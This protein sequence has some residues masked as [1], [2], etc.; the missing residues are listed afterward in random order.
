MP[1]IRKIEVTDTFHDLTPYQRAMSVWARW[2]RLDDHKVSTGEAH[3]QDV[4][5]MMRTAEAIETM[6]NDMPRHLWWAVRKGN[7]ICTVWNF[8][9]INLE[10]ALIAAEEKLT[11]KMKENVVTRRFFS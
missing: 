9:L 7:G 11:V 8:P 6:V 3:P 1:Q 10:D 4:K 2:M 5:E